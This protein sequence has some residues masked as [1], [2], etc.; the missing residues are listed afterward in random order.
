MSCLTQHKT[1][2]ELSDWLMNNASDNETTGFLDML[3]GDIWDMMENM[4]VSRDD[5][6]YLAGLIEKETIELKKEIVE[7]TK[8]LEEEKSV[9]C[10]FLG[11]NYKEGSAVEEILKEYYSEDFIKANRETWSQVGLFE[12]EE[13]DEEE[14]P[15]RYRVEINPSDGETEGRW[16]LNIVKQ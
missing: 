8:K 11:G 13:S 1:K 5:G 6:W 2:E 9:L 16:S 12:E 15:H 14:C 10:K 4:K 7:T 3:A